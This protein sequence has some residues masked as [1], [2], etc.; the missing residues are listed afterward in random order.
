MKTFSF[1]PVY[2]LTLALFL[3]FPPTS[4]ATESKYVPISP[5]CSPSLTET[6][7]QICPY[8]ANQGATGIK[9]NWN[10]NSSNCILSGVGN[11]W[12]NAFYYKDHNNYATST[13]PATNA[14]ATALGLTRIKSSDSILIANP[15][16]GEYQT[17]CCQNQ[18]CQ[19]SDKFRVPGYLESCEVGFGGIAKAF[20]GQSP[21][22]IT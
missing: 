11:N 4:W 20:Q 22:H 6:K 15:K 7:T 10:L 14:Q 18:V 3:L 16:I 21:I 19:F 2:F 1:A 8:N 5:S 17:T 9:L 12:R 13:I